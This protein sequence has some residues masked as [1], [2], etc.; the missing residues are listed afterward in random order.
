MSQAAKKEYTDEYLEVA[1]R[2]YD[3]YRYYAE[4]ALKIKPKTKKQ[5][6]LIP[7]VFNTAQTYIYYMLQRQKALIQKIRAFIVK[8]RQQGC[9]TF[10]QGMYFHETSMNYGV[11]TFIQTHSKDATANLYGI[12]QRFLKNLSDDIRPHVSISNT[13]KLT[14][15]EL[16]SGYS[17]STAG[18]KD[19]GRSD[20]IDHLHGS[21]VA[22]WGSTHDHTTGLLQAVPDAPNTS[23]IMEST[24]N[25]LGGYFHK[26]YTSAEA[27]KNGD[28]IAI[29]TPWYWQ[30]EYRKP[31]PAGFKLTEEEAEYIELYDTY[32]IF[33]ED[34]VIEMIT[35]K[36]DLEQMVWRRDKI[37]EFEGDVDRF[38]QEYPATAQMAFQYSAVDSFIPAKSVVAALKRPQYRS[39]GAIVGGFDP[40]LTE[41]GDKKGFIYRQG[42]NVWGLEYPKLK[43]HDAMVAFCKKKLDDKVIVLDRLF[44]LAGGGGFGIWDTLD[45]DG[46]C[47][48]D[49][50]TL[51][52]EGK[53]ALEEHK[54]VKK[55]A[56]MSDAVK[57]ALIDPDRPLSI[58]IDEKYKDTFTTELTSEGATE[59]SMNRTLIEKKDKVKVRTGYD[60]AGYDALKATFAEKVIKNHVV[61]RNEHFAVVDDDPLM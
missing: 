55:R 50:V 29:F 31:V 60:P 56:E 38:N 44:I 48:D 8:G 20:T 17:V 15:D 58:C 43:G 11:K 37:A 14:F 12:A 22:F 25:G 3:D 19:T 47:D 6:A 21:E 16:D 26:G 51:V 54:Y 52:N 24:A 28:Y 30:D 9:S 59:D 2:L 36:I 7:L 27:G 10:I 4:Q 49:R 23:I 46:Y 39:Y 32:P 53:G 1:V 61:G 34:W 40:S 57:Q 41:T 42:A 45:N 18:S 13:T 35:R 33:K 5:G